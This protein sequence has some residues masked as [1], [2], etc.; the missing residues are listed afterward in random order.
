MRTPTSGSYLKTSPQVLGPG[1]QPH[2]TNDFHRYARG[3]RPRDR[4]FNFRKRRILQYVY[5]WIFVKTL[6]PPPNNTVGSSKLITELFKNLTDAVS[7]SCLRRPR[8]ITVYVYKDELRTYYSF[9]FFHL[10]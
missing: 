5:T 7:E 9:F 10:V 2:R 8:I 4:V 6:S 1:N 3:P